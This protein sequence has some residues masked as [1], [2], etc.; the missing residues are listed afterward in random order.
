MVD[1]YLSVLEAVL[2]AEFDVLAQRLAF[3]LCQT[4]HNGE[5]HFTFRIHDIVSFSKNDSRLPL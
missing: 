1:P 2:Q 5:Q 3:L 4:R